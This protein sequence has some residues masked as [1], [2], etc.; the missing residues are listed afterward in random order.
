MDVELPSSSLGSEELPKTR[1][2]LQNCFNAGGVILPRPGITQITTNGRAARGSFVYNGFLYVVASTDLLKVTNIETGAFSVVDTIEGNGPI[3]VAIGFNH[4]VIISREN[5]GKGYTLTTGDVVTEI[6]DPDFAASNSVSH[7]NGRFVY[8]PYD[9][10]PAFF[11]DV[12]AGQTIQST[13]FFDA[14]ELPDENKVCFNYR[15]ILY[16]GGTD[17]FELFR[18]L[19]GDPV[20]YARLNSRIQYGYLGGILE[21]TDT[22][23]F[24]GN[25]KDEASGIY[26][27]TQGTAQKISNARIDLILSEYTDSQLELCISGRVKWRGYDMAIFTLANHSFAYLA[28][29]W[30]ILTSGLTNELFPGGYITQYQGKHYAVYGDKIGRFDKTNTDYGDPFQRLIEKAFYH[31]ENLAFSVGYVELGISQGYNTRTETVFD[32]SAGTYESKSFDFTTQDGSPTGI[33]FKTDGTV[34]YMLGETSDDVFQY[35]LSTAWDVSTASYASKSFAPSESTAMQGMFLD[36]TGTKLILLAQTGDTAAYGYTLSTAWDISTASYD[37]ETFDF[38]TQD[39]NPYGIW[40]KS[41]GLRMFMVGTTDA[42]YS[43]TLSTAWDVSTATYDSIT[44][45]VTNEGNGPRDVQLSSDGTSMWVLDSGANNI[46]E[47]LLTTAWDVSTAQYVEQLDVSSEGGSFRG[48]YISETQMKGYICTTAGADIYQYALE[49]SIPKA[50]T[51]ALELSR[52]NV[53]YS[54]PLYRELGKLGEYDSKLVWKYPGGL[55]YY[56]GFMGVRLSTY[57]DVNFSIDKLTVG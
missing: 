49:G 11:S 57:D 31:P 54:S 47:Y 35:T 16:I 42:I 30:V 15:N 3:D 4:A 48:M 40:F 8:I 12:G 1:E 7:V 14:E 56:E 51:V 52:D 36:S 29:Q 44:F 34:M 21:Y 19:G 28:G 13:S 24:I 45:D 46:N 23:L 50:G 55:G 53:L 9:G 5:L 2:T 18:D 6:T 33:Q 37:T 10:S 32:L 41:D 26:A 43:Y 20:P 25:E 39:A 17:S 38:S 27:I 22:F